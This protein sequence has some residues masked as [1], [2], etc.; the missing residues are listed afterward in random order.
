[1]AVKKEN[2]L[3]KH[4]LQRLPFYLSYL[5]KKKEEGVVNISS[6]MIANDLDLNGVQVRK[7]IACVSKRNGKPKM[8]HNIDLL[9]QDM[10][11]YLGYNNEE[12]A[13]I[14]GVGQLGKALLHYRGFSNYGLKIISAFDSDPNIIG[15][16]FNNVFVNSIN[17]VESIVKDLRV[18]IGIITVPDKYAQ[19][20]CDKLIRGGVLAIWNFA[21]I[22][23]NVPDNILVHNENMASSLAVL[24]RH[25]KEKISKKK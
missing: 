12:Y 5:K 9:I 10:E 21:P 25:L 8:G 4:A 24:S 18:R 17:D 13:V 1:M 6:P 7:D 3:S 16:E 2:K 14:V 11:S 22:H 19:E 15:K 23:L 20:V